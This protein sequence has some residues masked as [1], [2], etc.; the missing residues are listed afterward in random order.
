MPSDTQNMGFSLPR[1]I[2]VLVTAAIVGGIT[3]Y[4][5]TQ[6]LRE[7]IDTIDARSQNNASD[8]RDLRKEVVEE[9]KSLTALM[10]EIK[11]ELARSGTDEV[12]M[13]NFADQINQHE[14]LFDTIWPRLREM[15]ERIQALEGAD[16]GRW[17]Y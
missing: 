1:I 17:Q 16:A 6:V 11:I 8:I 5:S 10:V 15:K 4:G 13:A 12:R 14:K 9:V 7:Q 2:E 3:L